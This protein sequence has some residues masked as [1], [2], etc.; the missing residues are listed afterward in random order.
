LHPDHIGGVEAL[1]RQVGGSVPVA[2]HKLTAEALAGVVN[3]DSLIEEGEVIELGGD[4]PL[5]L[6][7][8]HTPGHA[9]G[10]LSLYEE[11]V[12]A[13]LCGDNVV[14][15]GSVLIEPGEGSVRDYLSTLERYRALPRLRLLLGG[16]GPAVAAP[17]E[18]ID[19][20]IA[21]RL[22][23]ERNIL[24]AVRAGA[25]SAAQIVA[26]VYTDVNPRMHAL[27]GRAVLAHL[28]KLEE[29]GLVERAGEDAWRDA[30]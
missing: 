12:G 19:E 18:K 1:R 5:L 3:V 13:L 9:R 23:R 8:M 28:L 25:T 27:A 2:A 17:R 15:I 4:P 29:D 24:S 22:E 6:R 10:H 30:A 20:Y 14:G 7:A 16:H 26:R 21:H 11:R